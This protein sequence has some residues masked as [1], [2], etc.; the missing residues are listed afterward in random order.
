MARWLD[1]DEMKAWRALVDVFRSVD[2]SLETELLAAHGLTNGDYG[3]LV[4]L[5]EAEGNR[6]RMCDL[7]G[8]LHLSPS[9]LTRRVDGLV[10]KGYRISRAGPR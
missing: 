4:V 6:L 9:G 3:V 2:A 10:K 7:A 1:D 5:S 8:A